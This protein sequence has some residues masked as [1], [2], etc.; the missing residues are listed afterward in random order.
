MMTPDSITVSLPPADSRLG[1]FIAD[2]ARMVLEEAEANRRQVQQV[3]TRPLSERVAA[4]RAIADVRIG[5]I[6]PDGLIPLTCPRNDSRFREGDLLCLNRTG[7]FYE[8]NLLVTLE[9]DEETEL[10]V[11]TEDPAVAFGDAFTHRAGQRLILTYVG[12][13]PAALQ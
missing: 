3:W 11:S 13:P 4:G 8:P 5:R 10:L 2:L 12:Q 7:P 9:A 6:G 1:A